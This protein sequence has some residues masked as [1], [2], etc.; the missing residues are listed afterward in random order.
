MQRLVPS[1]TA[2]ILTALEKRFAALGEGGDQLTLF[3]DRG[4]D[5][6]ELTGEE[7]YEVLVNARGP[8]WATERAEL[9]GLLRLA[10]EAAAGGADAKVRAFFI[11]LAN[12]GVRSAIPT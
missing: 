2:A 7:Q 12:C 1:S 4:E 11:C 9:T 5:W 3:R 10:R 6:A 8:A